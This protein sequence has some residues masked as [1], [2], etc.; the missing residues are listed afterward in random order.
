M[1]KSP[2]EVVELSICISYYDAP[3]YLSRC[4]T[5]IRNSDTR[6]NYEILVVD[7]ASPLSCAEAVTAVFPEA[8]VIVNSENLGYAKANNL[9]INTAAGHF[10]LVLNCDTQVLPGALDAMVAYLKKHPAAGAVGPKVLNDDGTLQPQCRRGFLSP[11]SSFAYLVGLDRLFPHNR[12]LGEYLL[13]YAN[14]EETHEVQSLSGACMMVR[15]EVIQQLGA[16]DETLV[17]YSEDLDWCYRIAA[18]DWCVVYLPNAEVIH[19]GGKG[20]TNIRFFR[21]LYYYHRN[22]WIIFCRY[23]RNRFFPLYGWLIALMVLARFSTASLRL[24][25]GERRVGTRK[26]SAH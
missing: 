24:L 13:R 6:C 8:R 21:S 17:Q 2:N 15:R 11:L 14:P 10:V 22:P 18:A 12:A 23:P 5:S 19:S 9:L 16:F 20:G 26:G 3:D 25:W 4:L 7:D 1:T